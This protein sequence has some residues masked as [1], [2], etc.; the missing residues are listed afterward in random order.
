MINNNVSSKLSFGRALTDEEYELYQKATQKGRNKLGLNN[1]ISSTIV[2]DVTLPR[3]ANEDTGI[4][5]TFSQTGREILG[6]VKK[7]TGINAVQSGPQGRI[8]NGTG[9]S[10]FSGTAFAIGSQMIDLQPLATE[11]YGNLLTKE[12]ITS[13][14]ICKTGNPNRVNYAHIRG[15]SEYAVLSGEQE[16]A[17]KTAFEKFRELEETSP[18]KQEY[19]EFVKKEGEW[20]KKDGLYGALAAMHG[21]D[22]SKWSEQD[23]DLYSGKFNNTEINNRE[24]E[25]IKSSQEQEINT[26]EF[27]N[28]KQFIADKQ[29]QETKAELNKQGIKVF[30]DALIGYSQSEVWANKAAFDETKTLGVPD[31]NNPSPNWG[32]P[33]LDYSKMGKI[34]TSS[35]RVNE[36]KLGPAGK[37]IY[38]K[39]KKFFER[40]DGVRIDAGW[41]LAKPYVFD[42][43]S[44]QGG[45]YLFD[46]PNYSVYELID[47]TAR[48][49]HGNRYSPENINIEL[50]GGPIDDKN[51]GPATN[52][53]KIQITRYKHENWGR[54][55]MYKI[56]YNNDE[57][58]FILGNGT[59]DDYSL[60][61]DSN[62]RHHILDGNKNRAQV[63]SKDMKLGAGN[64]EIYRNAKFG[65][66]LTTR[67]NF[68]TIWDVFGVKEQF[69]DPNN[70]GN[71]WG[72][73]LDK[74][75]EKQYFNALQK[76]EGYNA[77]KA[78]AM[79]IK[80]KLV[81]GDNSKLIKQLETL[82]AILREEGPTTQAEANRKLSENPVDQRLIEAFGLKQ[83]EPKTGQQKTRTEPQ[84]QQQAQDKRENPLQ[85]IAKSPAFKT[86]DGALEKARS[87]WWK[88]GFE[89]PIEGKQTPKPQV[90]LDSMKGDDWMRSEQVTQAINP[91]EIV[92]YYRNYDGLKRQLKL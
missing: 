81:Q 16:N 46:Q 76:G 24:Q 66:L 21:E 38:N 33:L 43:G 17:L 40:Y 77:P 8:D 90:M 25:I 44:Q 34:D 92:E 10:P 7:W 62:N 14:A 88:Q 79:A 26:Y 9:Y 29:Q 52:W 86:A 58:K 72:L 31:K 56:H 15:N 42:K 11:Q 39:Y 51:A 5:T 59:H 63:L 69:N 48:E 36:K 49:V 87:D 45:R 28:F 2:F 1:G 30:G 83:P 32:I 67:N 89:V 6:F 20:L 55:N 3:K 75:Y 50:L 65:E 18:L 37:L 74:D 68:S 91:N 82:G 64:A 73:R 27:N 57:S 84:Q 53:S 22:L 60:I 61:S 23:R 71:N 80:A 85:T 35:G 19:N 47:A 41:Q 13:S 54:A 4:G 12:D 70:S 78:M